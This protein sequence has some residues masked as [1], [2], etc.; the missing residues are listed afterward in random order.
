M[1]MRFTLDKNA[2]EVLRSYLEQKLKIIKGVV[3][4]YSII[5]KR[6]LSEISVISNYHEEWVKTYLDNKFQYIDPVVIMALRRSSPFAWNEDIT[7]FSDIKSTKIFSLS[8][9]YNIVNGYTFVLHDHA[10]NLATLSLILDA[11]SNRNLESE[12]QENKSKLQLLLIESHE[13]IA[14]FYADNSKAPF[15]NRALLT[16]RENEVL[17]WCSMGKTYSEIALIVGISPRT[18]KFHMASVTSKLGVINAKQ[19]IR[20]SMELDLIKRPQ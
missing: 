7:I 15:S 3:F 5:N 8:K 19:A 2:N 13:E 18:V 11:D 9:K 10:N 6:N 1:H 4:A 20:L 16:T 17:Y 14:T 12:I